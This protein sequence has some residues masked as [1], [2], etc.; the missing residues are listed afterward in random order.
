MQKYITQ[1]EAW[2]EKNANEIEEKA[3]KRIDEVIDVQVAKILREK[4]QFIEGM[5]EGIAKRTADIANKTL[6]KITKEQ[7]DKINAIKQKIIITEKV[8]II[9]M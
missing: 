9:K 2:V 5:A 6:K 4:K 3:K 1:G 8:V 7:I